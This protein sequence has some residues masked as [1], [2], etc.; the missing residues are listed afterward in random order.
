MTRLPGSPST[1]AW[2]PAPSTAAVGLLAAGAAGVPRPAVF[3][4]CWRNVAGITGIGL[5]SAAVLGGALAW[6]DPM[7][8]LVLT[9]TALAGNVTTPRGLT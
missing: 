5:L 8:C 3:R 9:E 2:S 6:A 7:A 4:P 1:Q